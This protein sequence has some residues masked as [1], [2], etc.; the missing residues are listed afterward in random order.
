MRE[1]IAQKARIFS[2]V[3]SQLPSSIRVISTS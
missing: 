1:S 2:Q 3:A